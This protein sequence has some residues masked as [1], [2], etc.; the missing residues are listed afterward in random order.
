MFQVRI[1]EIGEVIKTT[2]TLEKAILELNYLE[3][4]DSDSDCYAPNYYDIYDTV[5]EEVVS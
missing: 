2:E 3:S 4:E 5:A 1:K